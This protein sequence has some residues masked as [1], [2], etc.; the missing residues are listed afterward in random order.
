MSRPQAVPPPL[1]DLNG[2]EDLEK[3][4]IHSFATSSVWRGRKGNRCPLDRPMATP[5]PGPHMYP[6]KLPMWQPG[7]LCCPKNET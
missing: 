5:N 7:Y 3:S 6:A 1:G 4:G 2:Q